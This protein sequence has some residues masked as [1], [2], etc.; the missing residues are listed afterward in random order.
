L[1]ALGLGSEE[2][3]ASQHQKLRQHVTH[4]HTTIEV[5]CVA[6]KLATSAEMKLKRRW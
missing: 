2:L 3:V 4:V 6:F 1:T 5:V